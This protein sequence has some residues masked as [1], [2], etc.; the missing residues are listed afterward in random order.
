MFSLV[1]SY[2]ILW[3]E[4]KKDFGFL[5]SWIT[6]NRLNHI[7]WTNYSCSNVLLAEDAACP[8]HNQSSPISLCVAPNATSGQNNRSHLDV[9]FTAETNVLRQN[10][11]S[12][13]VR[14]D[15]LS[16][17]H[18]PQRGSVKVSQSDSKSRRMGAEE[19]QRQRGTEREMEKKRWRRR[20]GRHLYARLSFGTLAFS[21]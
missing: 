16:A 21:D 4:K 2:M 18:R 5:W 17:A 9:V 7:I 15:N 14:P 11:C 6:H 1:L 3:P 19:K 12:A 8:L 20:G 13:R 10:Y